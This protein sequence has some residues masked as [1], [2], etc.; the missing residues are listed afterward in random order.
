MPSGFAV[1]ES[2]TSLEQNEKTSANRTADGNGVPLLEVLDRLAV[3]AS[4]DEIIAATG[5]SHSE[6]RV[7]FGKA[8]ER[9]RQSETKKPAKDCLVDWREVTLP[10]A[11]EIIADHAISKKL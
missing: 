9:I 8:A 6:L 3:G 11:L 10:A 2:G 1:W 4:L 5:L 7:C